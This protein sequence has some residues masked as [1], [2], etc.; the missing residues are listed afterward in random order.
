M[1]FFQGR[2]PGSA[3]R[4]KLFSLLPESVLGY[5]YKRSSGKNNFVEFRLGVLAI[6]AQRGW[7]HYM[8]PMLI[9]TITQFWS[10]DANALREFKIRVQFLKNA[11]FQDVMIFV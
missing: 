9:M 7:V 6:Q 1:Y 5:Q 10:R 4:N 8:V 11:M 2:Q 3:W